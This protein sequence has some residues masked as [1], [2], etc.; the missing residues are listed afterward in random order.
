M[1]KSELQIK[2]CKI[3]YFV[4]KIA[5]TLMKRCLCA[6]CWN[7]LALFDNSNIEQRHKRVGL[8]C[9]SKYKRNDWNNSPSLNSEN[10]LKRNEKKTVKENQ[11]DKVISFEKCVL[12]DISGCRF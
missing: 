11:T 12:V 8:V 6:V 3:S 9:F 5:K 10:V 4:Q 7:P 1:H 2:V